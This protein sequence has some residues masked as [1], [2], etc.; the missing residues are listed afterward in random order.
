MTIESGEPSETMDAVEP[1][2]TYTKQENRM[3]K[4]VLRVANALE[5][6]NRHTLATLTPE[7][8]EYVNRLDNPGRYLAENNEFKRGAPEQQQK[9][10]ERITR[11]AKKDAAVGERAPVVLPSKLPEVVGADFLSEEPTAV[12]A[13]L[14][15]IPVPKTA[16]LAVKA[17]TVEEVRAVLVALARRDGKRDRG[18]AILAKEGA[19]AEALPGSAPAVQGGVKVL[20]A[21]YFGAVLAAVQALLEAK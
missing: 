1:A 13:A 14:E 18:L 4:A 21:K 17:V 16:V 8:R 20:D 10:A 12:P 15:S 11:E 5:R 7:Q 19:G 6:M 9:Q 3:Y 2:W